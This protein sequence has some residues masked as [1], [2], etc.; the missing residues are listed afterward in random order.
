MPALLGTVAREEYA[1]VLVRGG[2]ASIHPKKTSMFL[3]EL[4]PISV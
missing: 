1:H 3:V 4:P 2:A